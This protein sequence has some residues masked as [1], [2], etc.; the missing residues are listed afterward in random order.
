MSNSFAMP[1]E[2][3]KVIGAV[4]RSAMK[5]RISIWRNFRKESLWQCVGFTKGKR[6]AL[7]GHGKTPEE[8]Y[9][10][11]KEACDFPF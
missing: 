9:A 8:A 4:D 1:D 7:I 3:F 11:W 2:V 10:D 6:N 5:P